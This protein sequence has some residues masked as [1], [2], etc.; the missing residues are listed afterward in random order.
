MFCPNCRHVTPDGSPQCAQCGLVLTNDT[1][2]APPS[3]APMPWSPYPGMNASTNPPTASTRAYTPFPEQPAPPSQSGDGATWPDNGPP[4]FTPGQYP[5]PPGQSPRKSKWQ[6]AIAAVTVCAVIVGMVFVWFGTR[7]ATPTGGLA[8]K[9]PSSATNPPTVIVSTMT[10]NPEAT[11]CGRISDFIGAGRATI[12]PMF[13]ED[14]PFPPGSVSYL[15]ETLTEGQY[16]Y[17]LVNVCS[18]GLTADAARAYFSQSLPRSGW[19]QSALYPYQGDP[20]RACGDP[21]CWQQGSSTPRF[22]SLEQVQNVS[23]GAASTY[24]LRLATFSG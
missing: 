1:R 9:A 5:T 2:A 20:T 3:Q 18:N 11:A 13:P 15:G 19:T 7:H 8:T 17:D 16:S 23:N 14:I 10:A 4:V 24:V 22:I 21:Y 12:L 6:F